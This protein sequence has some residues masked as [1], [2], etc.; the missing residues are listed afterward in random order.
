MLGTAFHKNRNKPWSAKITIDYE[1]FFLGYFYTQ[2]E[3]HQAFKEACIKHGVEDRLEPKLKGKDYQKNYY[4]T[5]KETILEKKAKYRDDNRELINIR[6]KKT[7]QKVKVKKSANEKVV[8]D[9][10][11]RQIL[12]EYG[13]VCACCGEHRECMLTIDHIDSKG[14]EHRK[15][16]GDSSG[17]IY[18]WLRRNG[19]PKDNF[20]LLCWNCN[21]GRHRNGG[22]CPHE[23]ERNKLIENENLY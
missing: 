21:C 8:R 12:Q 18:K 10:L 5:K 9:A 20:R 16:V 14:N 23:I 19:F 17:N 7:Y 13:N 3:A 6:A 2:E 4:E 22:I 15:R 11:R 1:D